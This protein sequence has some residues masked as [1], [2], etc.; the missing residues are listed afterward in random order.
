MHLK[1]IYC[2]T[3]SYCVR[4]RAARVLESHAIYSILMQKNPPHEILLSLYKDVI[5]YVQPRAGNFDAF[6]MSHAFKFIMQKYLPMKYF[7]SLYE[8]IILQTN[9]GESNVIKNKLMHACRKHT[10]T[11]LAPLLLHVDTLLT[12]LLRVWILVVNMHAEKNILAHSLCNRC[13]V[14]KCTPFVKCTPFID[15]RIKILSVH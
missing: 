7:F 2:F 8:D 4:S 10:R 3:W 11:P 15:F 6:G 1:S 12:F 13:C 14:E 9:T 5:L